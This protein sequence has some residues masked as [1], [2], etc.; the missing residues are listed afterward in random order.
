VRT[1]Q[2]VGGNVARGAAFLTVDSY[3][4]IEHFGV[5]LALAG[6]AAAEYFIFSFKVMDDEHNNI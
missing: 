4:V 1:E 3:G 2:R 6:R 5:V